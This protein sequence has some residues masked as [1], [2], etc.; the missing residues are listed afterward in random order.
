MDR[1]FP[2]APVCVGV[3]P[4][5]PSHRLSEF[6]ASFFLSSPPR[7]RLTQHS[8]CGLHTR[9]VTIRDMS[10]EG[11]SHFI[12]SMTAPIASGWSGC[13]VGLAPTGKR[14]LC[15]AH[16]RSR[17]ASVSH[18]VADDALCRD[19]SQNRGAAPIKARPHVNAPEFLNPVGRAGH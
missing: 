5:K 12:T 8:R 1:I 16:T 15:T 6:F 18:R 10:I 9:A 4:C 13:R 11:F 7:L 19:R 2:W 17:H 3:R 14:R